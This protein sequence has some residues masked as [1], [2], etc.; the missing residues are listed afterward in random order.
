MAELAVPD[1]VVIT[2]GSIVKTTEIYDWDLSGGDKEFEF[3][4]THG[5]NKI[6]IEVNQ[7][8]WE[9]TLGVRVIDTTWFNDYFSLGSA[10]SIT[11]EFSDLATTL[12]L[13]QCYPINHNMSMASDDMLT[14]ELM[15]TIPPWCVGSSTVTFV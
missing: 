9:L 10:M 1:N 12:T 8:E 5:K 2:I 7:D 3:V 14:G 11:M 15:F 13:E 6:P 4:K